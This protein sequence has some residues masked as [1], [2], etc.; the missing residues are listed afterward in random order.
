ML[1]F[2]VD[3]EYITKLALQIL[4]TNKD[5]AMLMFLKGVIEEVCFQNTEESLESYQKAWKL[6]KEKFHFAL[7]KVHLTRLKLSKPDV[8]PKYPFQ[9]GTS[10]LEDIRDAMMWC[11]KET[12]SIQAM[13]W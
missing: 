7:F 1:I 10:T 8:V 13:I 11:V 12:G 9:K 5:S 2:E 6:S 3:P 4:S